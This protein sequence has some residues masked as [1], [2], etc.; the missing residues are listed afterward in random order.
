[1]LLKNGYWRGHIVPLVLFL[2]AMAV[3]AKA[4]ISRLDIG[5]E[6]QAAM[7]PELQGEA[8]G[9]QN[10]AFNGAKKAIL[11]GTLDTNGIGIPNWD[12]TD[13]HLGK[14]L[15]YEGAAWYAKTVFIPADY[16]GKELRL[17]ME[18]TKVTKVWVNGQYAGG[19]DMVYTPQ[20]ID[21]TKL[22]KV[23][24]E[25]LIV[26]CVNNDISLV[27]VM[28]SHA[29]SP[30][31]QTNW[32]GIIGKF[33][34]QA[35]NPQRIT[36]L[37]VT[38]D[39][40]KKEFVVEL[41]LSQDAKE[42][43]A[44]RAAVG[45][46]SGPL[47]DDKPAFMRVTEIAIPTLKAGEQFTV[48]VPAGADAALWSDTAPAVQALELHL[49]NAAETLDKRT[50]TV[51]LREFK[52]SYEGF[53]INGNKTFLRGK[54]DA[55]AFPMS[56]H[57]PMEVEGWLR[58]MGISRDWGMN[59]YRFHTCT[60]PEAAF[61]AADRLGIYI[62]SELPIWWAFDESEE[63]IQWQLRQGRAILDE[64]A[65]HPSFVMMA[66]GNEIPK[67]QSILARMVKELRAHDPRPLYAQGSNNHLWDPSYQEGDDFFTSARTGPY[68]KD[69]LSTARMSMSYLDSN[70]EGGLLN[71]RYPSTTINFDKAME[72]SPVP[73]LGF[74]VGQYQVYP[75]FKEL[76]KYS[77]VL[78]PY[79]LE[80]YKARLEKAGMLD[81]AED[82]FLA[83]GAL[84]LLGYRA[85]IEAMLRT[86]RYCGFELLDLQD[87][88][89]QGTALVGMLDAFMDSKGL[90]RPDQWR[91]FCDDVVI[92]LRQP[93]FCWTNAETYT[94]TLDLAN[95]GPKSFAD[96]MISWVL[97]MDSKVLA[98]GKVG[99]DSP[100]F[101]GLIAAQAG[102]EIPLGQLARCVPARLD[103]D[104]YLDGS[105]VK[106]SYPIWVYPAEEEVEIPANVTVAEALDA[107]TLGILAKGGR[108]LLFPKA[109]AIM[110][111]S[112]GNQFISE[113]WNWQMFTGFAEK[114]GGAKSPGTLGLL[115][116][117]RSPAV[118]N[119]PTSFHT[120][121]QWWAIVTG[122]RALI[123]DELPQSYRP[124][125]QVIDNIL[126]V[127]KLGLL[128]EFKLGEGRL[129]VCTSPL[130]E[131]LQYA[132]ARQL[133]RSLLA[134]AAS[135]AFAPKD[136]VSA[137]QLKALGL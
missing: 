61:E 5:G 27:P 136:E 45:Q 37:R 135:D 57:P 137:E 70:G 95:Y 38:P 73:F 66:L 72:K 53:T 52:G 24:E 54:H 83:S 58:V 104:L 2:L 101:A 103:I 19:D 125:I 55:M 68:Q 71:S 30:D 114:S 21:L 25:N 93:K 129:I 131:K 76:T 86:N 36:K 134:Y 105:G 106:N 91:Q 26:I 40:E 92:L 69:G 121:Y 84:S 74:E 110:E 12:N 17:V 31:T 80:M 123:L 119:F 102:I 56:G 10:G 43:L 132:E 60:P 15:A 18:R 118:G 35:F 42:G 48:R 47:W 20:R 4:Q 112:T 109:E 32:N 3:P 23:G 16:A 14:P 77:G 90:V 75:N 100:A 62:Q 78:K 89:G 94:A 117:T 128:C 111:H 8:L 46:L 127:H 122:S 51:A 9:W 22:L 59:H 81:Q 65:D 133:L 28:G 126:R 1:M 130:P 82:F 120:D 44:L 49:M 50:L 88:P 67:D 107:E 79:N 64:Y 63:Q 85:D 98:E 7:D 34:I 116:N 124:T 11:P 96:G 39:V 97:R 6:W 13:Q 115:I 41:R 87:Y 113:F 99:I 29:Y 108:V 33:E